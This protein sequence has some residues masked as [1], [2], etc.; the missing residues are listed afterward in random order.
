MKPNEPSRTALIIARQRVA[1]RVLDHGSMITKEFLAEMLGFRRT[2][3]TD[4]RSSK[5]KTPLHHKHTSG[6]SWLLT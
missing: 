4:R 6:N 1:H 5:D 3:V 2:T